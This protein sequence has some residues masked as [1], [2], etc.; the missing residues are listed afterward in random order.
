MLFGKNDLRDQLDKYDKLFLLFKV[1]DLRERLLKNH[2]KLL[3]TIIRQES[4]CSYQVQVF[5]PVIIISSIRVIS[6]FIFLLFLFLLSL[7]FDLNLDLCFHTISKLQL[8]SITHWAH[9]TSIVWLIIFVAF[10]QDSEELLK[11]KV[12]VFEPREV[13]HPVKNVLFDVL[14]DLNLIIVTQE[15]CVV[16]HYG[17]YAYRHSVYEVI[18]LTH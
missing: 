18:L 14:E 12:R 15:Q 1:C 16:D 17:L 13:T 5:F 2:I 10:T 9:A 8:F 4:L 11:E 6:F 3:L 7:F